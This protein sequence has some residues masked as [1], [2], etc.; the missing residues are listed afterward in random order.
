VQGPRGPHPAND[1][2]GAMNNLIYLIGLI[3]VVGLIIAF[4]F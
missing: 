3:V 4:L 2:G 1:R